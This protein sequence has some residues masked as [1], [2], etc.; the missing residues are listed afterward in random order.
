MPDGLTRHLSTLHLDTSALLLKIRQDNEDAGRVER[1]NARR[2]HGWCREHL[3]TP[4]AQAILDD[5][6]RS[7]PY[8]TE[9]EEPRRMR[10]PL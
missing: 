7:L 2:V 3:T 1:N 5:A 6:E 4:K 9:P 8:L 10:M